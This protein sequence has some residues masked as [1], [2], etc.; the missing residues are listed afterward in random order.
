MAHW[1]WFEQLVMM[2]RMTLKRVEL[3][4]SETVQYSKGWMYFVLSVCPNLE[5]FHCVGYDDSTSG[6]VLMPTSSISL[7]DQQLLETL[8]HRLV[9]ISATSPSIARCLPEILPYCPS[10]KEISFNDHAIALN[11]SDINKERLLCQILTAID[12]HCPMIKKVEINP[13][14]TSSFFHDNNWHPTKTSS[15]L[16]SLSFRTSYGRYRGSG[17]DQ[18]LAAFIEQHHTTLE[19]ISMVHDTGSE[20]SN[21]TFSVIPMQYVQRL[22]ELDLPKV[23]DLC[24]IQPDLHKKKII[25]R[26]Q[27]SELFHMVSQIVQRCHSLEYLQLTDCLDARAL[28]TITLDHLRH[29]RVL[30]LK[31]QLWDLGT[32]DWNQVEEEDCVKAIDTLCQIFNNHTMTLLSIVELDIG[33]WVDDRVLRAIGRNDKQNHHILTRLR[34]GKHN[35]I[36]SEGLLEFAKDMQRSRLTHL[37]IHLCYKDAISDILPFST[38][39][40]L[41]NVDIISTDS[42]Y[43]SPRP[44]V[45]LFFAHS[46]NTTYLKMSYTYR[47]ARE[48]KRHLVYTCK[49]KDSHG[50]ILGE[51][52]GQL[53]RVAL[54]GR[55]LCKWKYVEG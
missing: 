41:I 45:A 52:S 5:T 9:R 44:T 51:Q 32:L 43:M 1:H 29:L 53:I 13:H 54:D 31:T 15:G 39:E 26:D 35:K 33:R 4:E 14:T 49:M 22:S 20:L 34:I 12:Q 47:G 25:V 30:R 2:N 42:K 48:H 6:S 21:T 3:H 55:I 7:V 50:Y 11:E 18:V 36:T 37:S 28:Q 27:L 38:L 40:Y 19:K 17:T 46:P 10:L 16:Q 24:I 8:S 23:R